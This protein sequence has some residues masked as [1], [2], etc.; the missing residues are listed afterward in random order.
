[1]TTRLLDFLLA[2]SEEKKNPEQVLRPK[3]SVGVHP[4]KPDESTGAR[5]AGMIESQAM[6]GFICWKFVVVSL[7]PFNSYSLS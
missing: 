4:G 6:C 3:T 5:K 2:L 1:M 7:F